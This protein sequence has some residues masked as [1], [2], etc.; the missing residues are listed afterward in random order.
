MRELNRV[1]IFLLF[2]VLTSMCLALSN[3][4][5]DKLQSSNLKLLQHRWKA[6]SSSTRQTIYGSFVSSWSTTP[7]PAGVYMEWTKDGTYISDVLG[8][9]YSHP[10]KLTRDSLIV[11]MHPAT[12]GLPYAN[13]DTTVIRSINDSALIIYSSSRFTSPAYNSLD[14]KIISLSR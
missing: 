13:P 8:S 12:A 2:L 9:I 11:N 4:G 5:K 10:Y 1:K 7:F 14:E 3:C 6:V